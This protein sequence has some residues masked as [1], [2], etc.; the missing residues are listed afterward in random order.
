MTAHQFGGDWTKTKLDKLKSYLVPYTQIF[1]KNKQ[2]GYFTT[3]YVDAFAGTGACYVKKENHEPDLFQDLAE[4][5]TQDYLKGSALIA[6][7]IDPGFKQYL[8]IEKS[9]DHVEELE[10]LKVC[11]PLKAKS[12]KIKKGGANEVLKQWCKDTPWQNNRA[13]VFLDPYGMQVE[14]ATLKALAETRAVDL[15]LLFPLGQAV[16][17]LLTKKGP[18]PPSWEKRL[19]TFFGETAWKERFYKTS[20][21]KGLFDE[22]EVSIEKTAGFAEIGDYM[23]ERLESIF[24]AVHPNPYPLRNSQNVPLFLLFFAVGN[25]DK[26]AISLA[27]KIA[28]HLL[29]NS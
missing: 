15:W 29:K 5:T 4:Q 28:S 11:F 8:F 19:T 16:M 10:K 12:I 9:S 22:D 13:V 26:K 27:M 21:D 7:E 20:I 3:W 2:A 17:R 14:W 24:P 23:V 25:P 1:S 6:L 18:P